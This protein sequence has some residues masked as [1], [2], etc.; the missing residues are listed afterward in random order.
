MCGLPFKCSKGGRR[1][2]CIAMD[3]QWMCSQGVRRYVWIAMDVFSGFRR[4]V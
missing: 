3:V 2:L 4:D 1:N